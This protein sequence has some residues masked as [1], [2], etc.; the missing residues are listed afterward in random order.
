MLAA[1]DAHYDETSQIGTGAAVVFEEWED[2]HSIAEYAAECSSIEPYI[3]GEFYRRELPCL[4]AVLEKVQ[5]P[6]NPIVVDGYVN[7]GDKPALGMYLWK[8]L[9]QKVPIVGV[10]KTLFRSAEAIEVTR[11]RS[12]MPL[13]VTAVGVDPLEAAGNVRRMVGDFRVPLC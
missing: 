9:D 3:P 1:L 7:L 8:A 11:G 2:A 4:M 12:K 13:F 5:E 6:L 10:A